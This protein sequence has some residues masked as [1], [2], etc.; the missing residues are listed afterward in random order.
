MPRR[1]NGVAEREKLSAQR[2]N[3]S[4]R[5]GSIRDD[6]LT[7]YDNLQE[8]REVGLQ[9]SKESIVEGKRMDVEMKNLRDTMK[10]DSNADFKDKLV[11]LRR[12]IEQEKEKRRRLMGRR[13]EIDARIQELKDTGLN[14]ARLNARR[15]IDRPSTIGLDASS[16]DEDMSYIADTL[17]INEIPNNILDGMFIDVFTIC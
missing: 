11:D 10:F 6:Q 8:E 5:K 16:R 7:E 1:W 12:N 4:H 13:K 9:L 15:P 3:W 14:G 2:R 17:R